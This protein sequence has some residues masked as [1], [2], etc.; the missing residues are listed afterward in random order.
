[1]T[2][3]WIVRNT[4]SNAVVVSTTDVSPIFQISS[5]GNY[6]IELIATSSAGC[7]RRDT[8]F[9]STVAPPVAAFQLSNDS[10]CGPSQETVINTSSG[11]MLSYLWDFGPAGQGSTDTVPVLPTFEAPIIADTIYH[12]T[13]SVTNMC[14]TRNVIDSVV[15]RP[16]PVAEIGTNYSQGCSPFSPV[17]QNVS[18]GSP[19][20]FLWDFGDGSSS[21]DS[22]PPANSYTTVDTIRTITIQLSI[23]N[24]CGTANAS[25]V[26]QVYPTNLS[27]TPPAPISGC[28]P[29]EASFTFPLGDLSFYLW[30]FGDSTGLA[31]N[32]V[33]HIYETPGIYQVSLTVS[34]FCL[35]DTIFSTVTVNPGPQLSFQIDQP[36]VC[37]NNEIIVQNTSSNAGS[38]FINFGDGQQSFT[39]NSAS[40]SYDSSGFQ[41]ISLAGIHPQNGCADTIYQTIEVIPYPEINVSADPDTGCMPLIVQFY[42]TTNFATG[43]EWNFADGTG[44]I[45]PE[46]SIVLPESGDFIAQL[47]AHNYQGI[48]IDCPDTVEVS[49]HVLPSPTSSFSLVNDTACGPPVNASVIN[50]STGGDTYTW[51]WESSSSTDFEPSMQFVLTGLHEIQLLTEN[52][53]ACRDTARNNFF[54]LG[55]PQIELAI[56]PP[57]G[58]APHTVSF[59]NLTQYGDSVYWAFGDGQFSALNNPVH[60]YEEAGLY[61][62]ELFVSAGDLCFDDSLLVQVIEVNPSAEAILLVTPTT[63]SEAAP[64][65][66]MVNSSLNANIFGLYEEEALVSNDVPISY[67]FENADTGLVQLALVANNQFNCPDTAYSDVYI[68]A[69][70]NIYIPSSFSPNGDGKND[71][72]SPSLDRNPSYYYFSIYDRWGHV[73]FE[74]LKRDEQWNGT[75]YN[76]G[77]KPLKQDVYVYKLK[78]V[79]E[80]DQIYNLIGNITIV[81]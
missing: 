53:Y 34:N 12:V 45:L 46:P 37:Q 52:S 77:R 14:G 18:Y 44:S 47:I 32:D 68:V 33:M 22:L 62:V 48:G 38:L 5:V 39:A 43:Y 50:T 35:T 28:S 11:F 57:S 27:A 21:N 69:S 78:A 74:T 29:L 7:V 59:A 75:Y 76:L 51:L 70:P 67:T 42:N 73:V 61:S 6:S 66:S 58:C 25:S 2:F 54:V 40:H 13:L 31:G 64:I 9:F 60:V 55:Q 79:F 15:L 80:Q 26:I 56:E 36:S 3:E 30:D 8:S 41:T 4:L 19:D 24:T 81:H 63:I 65:V 71:G 10:V 17:Y 72:F 23:G 20:W 1:M 16:I 49:I